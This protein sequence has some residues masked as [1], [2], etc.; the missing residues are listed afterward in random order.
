MRK[1]IRNMNFMAVLFVLIT[2]LVL[3]GLVWQQQRSH[4]DLQARVGVPRTQMAQRFTNAGSIFTMD[5]EEL[6]TSQTGSREYSADVALSKA[7]LHIVGVYSGVMRNTIEVAYEDVLLGQTRSSLD[8]ILL[9]VTGKGLRG[10]DIILTIDSELSKKALS[11]LGD[12]KG[13]IVVLNYRTGDVLAAVSTPT[14]TPEEALRFRDVP[15]SSLFNR[16]LNS[17]YAPGSSFKLLTATAWLD[18]P[19]FNEDLNL[20]CEGNVP[21]SLNGAVERSA[22]DAHGELGLKRA[23]QVSCNVFFGELGVKMGYYRLLKTAESFGYGQTI[24]L[25]RLRVAKSKFSLPN[26]SIDRGL[27]SWLSIGQPAGESHNEL[28]AL[29]MALQ[30][31]GL[32]NGGKIM[33]PHIIRYFHNPLGTIYGEPERRVLSVATSGSIADQ[34]ANLAASTITHGTGQSAGVASHT[35]CGKTGTVQVA[36]QAKTNAIFTGFLAEDSTPFALAVVVEDV[37]TGA[38]YAAPLA[39]RLFMH[40]LG[41]EY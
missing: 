32:A 33:E 26:G 5:G 35:V 39:R 1:L 11:L 3:F 31:G 13:A 27:L 10:D 2:A 20:V 21:L 16:V 37:G 18:S 23:L 38:E 30:V 4:R 36:G 25:D 19:L 8:Q 15:E 6:A 40:M 9:D 22:D 17:Q 12:R 41:L 28:S 29:Q 24:T 34:V 14:L 7:T